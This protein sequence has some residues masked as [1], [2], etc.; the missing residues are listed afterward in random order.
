MFHP[1]DIV[2]D[3]LPVETEQGQE[4]SE[5]LVAPRDVARQSF[6]RRRQD[7]PAIFFVFQEALRVEPLHHVT[8]AGLG[9]PEARG[10][11]HDAG[12][13]LRVD[14]IE[15]PLEIIFDRGRIPPVLFGCRHGGGE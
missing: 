1:L 4:F 15:D 9:N 3:H 2:M 11:V 12:I 13:S 14:Q 7:E 8:H 5:E 6:P 10:D